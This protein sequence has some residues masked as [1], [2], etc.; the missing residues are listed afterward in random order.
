MDEAAHT[1]RL[2]FIVDG[3]IV[4]DGTPEAMLAQT[5]TTSLEEAVLAL[6]TAGE[7]V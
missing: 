2:A 3:R 7:P 6:T 4:A 1:D 5:G